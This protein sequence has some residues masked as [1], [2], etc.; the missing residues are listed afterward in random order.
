MDVDF[1]VC[2][3]LT[4]PDPACVLTPGAE[5]GWCAKCD[6]AVRVSQDSIPY[7]LGGAMVICVQCA[8]TLPDAIFASR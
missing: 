7:V 2:C 8:V 3:R 4:D 6:A 1:V 5:T